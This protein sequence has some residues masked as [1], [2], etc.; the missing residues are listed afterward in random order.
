MTFFI[1]FKT[2]S[3]A[4][5]EK[6]LRLAKICHRVAQDKN[7]K[8]IPLVQAVDLFRVG[9]AVGGSVWTQHVDW[10]KPGQATGWV[11]LEA[12]MASGASGT[13]LNHSEH[14][15]PPG[16]IKQVIKRAKDLDDNFRIMVCG[17][18]LGQLK[19]LV[20]TKPDYLAYEIKEL[21][22][23]KDSIT[24]VSPGSVRKAIIIA[25][26]K[27][28]PLIVGAGV[29]SQ[30]DVL[31]AKKMGAR[32]VLISSAMVLASNPEKK[33]RELASGI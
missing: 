32:G 13:L 14:C 12:I 26:E 1:N 28:I 21:I 4:T 2:Y 9:R 7:V 15:L 18:T 16:T 8:I 23:G 20:F 19:K 31:L 30:E 11:N 5:G 17:G 3:E 29:N 24:K 10:Q 27:N 22:G 6:A 33:L 25:K